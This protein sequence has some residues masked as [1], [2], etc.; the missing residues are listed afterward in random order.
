MS[1]K[2]KILIVL[3][4]A[5][6]IAT[7]TLIA[8]TKCR[9]R[10]MND[11]S[12]CDKCGA[13]YTDGRDVE[14]EHTHAFNVKNI[15]DKYL[16]KPRDCE[17]ADTY[18]YS[19]A[20]GEAGGETFTVG[21]TLGHT[22]VTD[23]AK[24]PTCTESGLTE[25]SHCSVCNTVLTAQTEIDALGHY[26][27]SHEAK[28]PTCTEVGWDEYVTCSRCD[29]T[30]YVEKAALG[31]D[32]VA[33]EGKAP[34]CT[35]VGWNEYRTCDRCD[36]TT[37]QEIPAAGHVY[38][39]EYD[40]SCNVCGYVRDAECIHAEL[41]TIAGKAASCTE[42]GLT[43]GRRCKKC[44]ETV[45]AQ[46]VIPAT[47]HTVVTDAAKA[48]TCTEAG[49]TEGTHC[50]VCNTLLT[51]QS[52]VPAR[53]HVYDDEYDESCNVCGYV[54]DVEC[55]HTE[56]VKISG[57]DATCTESGLTDGKRCKNCG[58]IIT[59]QTVIPAI[60]HTNG[61]VVKENVIEANCT[62]GG[63]YDEV[64]YCISCRTELRRN[65]VTTSPNGN[66]N[67][68]S[69]GVHY[70]PDCTKYGYD[71]VV[72]SICGQ[73]S[74]KNL[75]EPLGHN[76]VIDVAKAP[77]CTESGL[78]EG[79]HCSR[80]DIILAAQ[81]TLPAAGHKYDDKYDE[82]CNVCG[83]VRDA[84]CIH[85]EL[86]TIPGKA[87]TCTESGLTDGAKC[88][89]CGETVTE[90][91]VIP[92][93]GHT[94]GAPVKE[95]EIE[96]TC[97][98][99]GSYDEVVYCSKCS[100]E[101][102][103]VT[104]TLPAAGH[105]YDDEYDESCNVCGYIRDAKC[106]HTE[107]E[108]V[109]GRAAS[110]TESGLTDGA[111]CKKCGETVTEQEVI[112]AT[113]HTNIVKLIE[114]ELPATCTV[115]GLYDEV[116]YC[117]D[118]GAELDRFLYFTPVIEHNYVDGVCTRCG[119]EE[120][121]LYVRDG[122][123]IYFGEYPQTIKAD[124]VTIDLNT[125]DSRGYYLGSD[126]YYYAAVTANPYSS[127]YTF[128]NNAAV[129]FGTVYY[130]KVEPIRWRILEEKNGEAFL[131]C[132]FIIANIAYQSSYTSSNGNY[133]TGIFAND[134][135]YSEVRRWLNDEF[136][137]TAFTTLEKEIILTTEVDNSAES[138][139][140]S[141]NPYVCAN[142]Y[143]KIFLL[144]YKEVTNSSYGFAT[145]STTY[146]V[147]RRIKTS[148]YSRATGVWMSTSSSYY[149]NGDWW[150]RSPYSFDSSSAC[151]IDNDGYAYLSSSVLYN[152][153][154]AVPALKIRVN[155]TSVH[156]HIPASAMKENI[157]PSAC[158][159]GGSYD[160]VVYC[161]DCSAEL[162]RTAK[163]TPALGHNYADG[164]CTRCGE[165]EPGYTEGPVYVRDG[166]YIY[167]GEYPQTIKADSV[168]IDLNTQDSRGYYLGSDGYYYAA[169]TANPYYDNE[170]KFTNNA[171]VVSG[172]V[173][174]FKVEPIR[175]RILEEKSG[176][177]FLLCDFIIA[178]MAYQPSYRY[179]SSTEKYYTTANGAPEGT[180]QNNYKYSEV[181]R[182]L[183]A[184]FYNTAFTAFE[185][186]IILTTNVDNSVES[187]GYASNPYVCENTDDKIFLLSQ[188]EATN[189]VYG[190]ASSTTD[191]ARRMQ[192]SD[193]SRATGAYMSTDS[194]YYGNGIWWLRSPN[195]DYSSYA[196]YVYYD[197][198]VYN[199]FYVYYSFCGTVP[200]LKIM[201]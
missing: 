89:K 41:E 170:Y 143:D 184:D 96:S 192:T 44:G 130:F 98:N 112:P 83:Y 169:V 61:S 46:E 181:R 131:L 108:T 63:S 126:G 141:S 22:E 185:R 117:L 27:V 182:W 135:Q 111:K 190:F 65:T 146:D 84:E 24:A 1:K 51:A 40:E 76:V 132:D 139:V 120:P 104:E 28:D 34:T 5:L 151:Y 129:L 127:G 78:T 57:K 53:G 167:F 74:H 148:D 123:Y 106:R 137:N 39:D 37:Y 116:V 152:K 189:S 69:A 125:Q 54:R 103:R 3:L 11:D 36:Y 134:Y 198:Y 100:V 133:I 163:S 199:N 14:D 175:W 110:C 161:L 35:E 72:C 101:L 114:N 30:T 49:L 62:K 164:V 77:T 16:V 6:L 81:N 13:A 19:C 86:E 18:C 195:N 43:D 196:R 42:S 176:E 88:K 174:Y 79:S 75:I 15:D 172:T 197:G 48:P 80:C 92:A 97:T 144:S 50:S 17:S 45:T 26:G 82:S 180:Y 109:S 113:G 93:T 149:G 29:Y 21:E 12:F 85:A 168:T 38:D 157:I 10:D 102:S 91:E 25:G 68:V 201:L 70:D 128:T 64:V 191:T 147:A 66:H 59:E 32:K 138:T 94:S 153:L 105:K 55:K 31:H 90:Q 124:D 47:G 187:T 150:L 158:T 56:L 171:T 118:C 87:A 193:Y 8:I 107:L 20:C 52:A 183:N 162:E 188:K 67:Y 200:A 95:N 23:A 122:N 186:E 159:T 194:S 58:E 166:N 9:H 33:H 142:T 121:P 115:G 179:D 178:N 73:Y 60:G 136:Y 160:E 99:S 4:S 177:A 71:I 154:G 119:K 156:T 173:Y 155:D 140:D 165:K 145:S 7:A 2:L